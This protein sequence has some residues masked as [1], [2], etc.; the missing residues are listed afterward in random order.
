MEFFILLFVFIY[1]Q[2]R[3]IMTELRRP[4]LYAVDSSLTT[5]Q[6]RSKIKQLA[7]KAKASVSSKPTESSPLASNGVTKLSQGAT[8]D[9]LASFGGSVET[10]D[11]T[12]TSVEKLLEQSG[13]GIVLFTYP[14]ASTP[15]CTTQACL[16]RDSYSPITGAS[17]EVY[18][19]STDSPKSNTTFATKQN[20]PYQLLC[21]PK[22]T[23]IKAIGMYKGGSGSG[24]SRGVVVIDKQGVCKVWFQGGVSLS[25]LISCSEFLSDVF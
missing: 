13:A 19:L 4:V 17:L 11:G 6:N 2:L 7:D 8:I 10:H 16:F 14:K 1:L 15:G 23:L 18:G 20:L 9:D 22:A 3:H 24:T 21:D 12:S 25:H 5:P